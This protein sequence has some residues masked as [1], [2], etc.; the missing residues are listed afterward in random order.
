M[1]ANHIPIYILGDLRER[2]KIESETEEAFMKRLSAMTTE[3]LF[4]EYCNWHGLI[5]WGPQLRGALSDLQKAE[6][7]V[8]G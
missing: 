6:E 7:L 4:D 1:K 8:N 5:N 3:K 2:M